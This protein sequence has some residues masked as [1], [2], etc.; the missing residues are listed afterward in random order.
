MKKKGFEFSFAWL[1]AIIV[2]AVIIFLA[3]FAST[4][5]IRTGRYQMDT[6]TAEQ[7]SIIFEPLETG[8]A[9]GK[10]NIAELK[11]ETRIYN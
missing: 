11:A 3:I 4:R 1:F 6:I 8:L 2:G 9:S 10:S 5:F 7:L